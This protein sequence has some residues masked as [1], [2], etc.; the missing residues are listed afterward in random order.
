MSGISLPSLATG[1]H[2]ANDR[3]AQPNIKHAAREHYLEGFRRAS[4][5]YT[6]FWM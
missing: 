5:D 4:L 3:R 1:Q 6:R 2:R